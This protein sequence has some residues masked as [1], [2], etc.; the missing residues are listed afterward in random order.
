MLNK[1]LRIQDID[2]IYA[3]RT[4]IR[5][6]H[7]QIAQLYSKSNLR[8]NITLYRGQQMKN[9]EFEELKKNQGGLLFFNNF[10]S[11]SDNLNVAKVFANGNANDP[12]KTRVIFVIEINRLV[13]NNVKFANIH[14][15]S[16]HKEEKE[17]L[18]SVGSIFRIGWLMKLNN[19]GIWYINLHLTHERDLELTSLT[20]YMRNFIKSQNL[21]IELGKLMWE[22]GKYEQTEKL[23]LEALKAEH[24]W[25]RR[26]G[27]LNRLG[28]ICWKKNDLEKAHDFYQQALEIDQQHMSENDPSFSSIYI[29]LGLIYLNQGKLDLAEQHFQHAYQLD[30]ASKYPKKE[31]LSTYYNNMASVLAAQEKYEEALSYHEHSLKT[32]LEHLPSVHPLIALSHNNIAIILMRLN[33]LSEAYEHSQ[34]AVN[35]ASQSLLTTHPDTKLYKENLDLISESIQQMNSL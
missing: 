14:R 3:M 6:I 8:C 9:N 27:I 31:W 4:Y 13:K 7:E 10:L 11:C 24:E 35:I 23:Y 33:R 21:L 22:M 16:A 1:A 29:N 30:L 20:Q 2:T 34:K 32:R 25:Q 28:M 15:I 18:F 19:D 17:W 26:S 12:T 5:H